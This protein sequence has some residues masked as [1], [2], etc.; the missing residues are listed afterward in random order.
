[1]PPSSFRRIDLNSTSNLSHITSE[2]LN[3]AESHLHTQLES[4]GLSG[5]KEEEVCKKVLSYWIKELTEE[6]LKSNVTVN[7]SSYKSALKR[8]KTGQVENLD[9]QL[10]SKVGNL[11]QTIDLLM[12]DAVINRK[13]LPLRK[14]EALK[15]RMEVLDDLR[16]KIANARKSVQENGWGIDKDQ[17]QA[18]SL[19]FQGS[20]DQEEQVQRAL[21]T[22]LA[23]AEILAQ[24]VPRQI[25]ANE[26]Q[27]ELVEQLRSMPP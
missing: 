18:P 11:S 17:Y 1:M 21:P 12:E 24:N 25:K 3:N 2:I 8:G 27:R 6:R 5:K 26:E 7:G 9:L 14:A 13:E 4:D 20:T 10:Q 19:P 16:E 22:A 15:A 23:Q